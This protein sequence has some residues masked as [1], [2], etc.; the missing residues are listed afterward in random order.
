MIPWQM[1]RS[2]VTAQEHQAARMFGLAADGAKRN[3]AL[4]KPAPE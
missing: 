2:V 3:G 1:V 4:K